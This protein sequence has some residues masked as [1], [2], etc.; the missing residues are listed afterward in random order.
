MGKDPQICQS[1]IFPGPLPPSSA[2][3]LGIHAGIFVLLLVTVLTCAVYSCGSVC[4]GPS[5]AGRE[6]QAGSGEGGEG[7]ASA[8]GPG[9]GWPYLLG[10]VA[11]VSVS[12]LLTAVP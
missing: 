6:G 8:T 5:R 9:P 3:M 4:G 1:N 12:C 11:S 7:Q 10:D 2:L